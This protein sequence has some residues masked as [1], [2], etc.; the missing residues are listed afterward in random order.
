MPI[1]SGEWW[2]VPR[3]LPRPIK[4]WR[5]FAY[6]VAHDLRAPLRHIDGFAKLLAENLGGSAD[7][8]ARHY[9]EAIQG[10]AR[11]MGEMVDDLLNLSRVAHGRN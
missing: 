1:W 4:S 6:S 7:E 3:N 11:N 9:L 5:A 8:D 10:G 2:S